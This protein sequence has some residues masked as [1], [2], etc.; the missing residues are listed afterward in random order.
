MIIL[1][2]IGLIFIVGGLVT[3]LDNN[4]KIDNVK[5]RINNSSIR[6]LTEFSKYSSELKTITDIVFRF[7]QSD[8]SNFMK[9]QKEFLEFSQILLNKYNS[10]SLVE[11]CKFQIEET[12]RIY[13]EIIPELKLKLT[14]E[15]REKKLN[16][17]LE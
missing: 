13:T 16:K 15:S 12:L 11:T 4:K 17:L 2:I 1:L 14:Q 8:S 10:D 5:Q 7:Y 9:Y 3:I 6:R